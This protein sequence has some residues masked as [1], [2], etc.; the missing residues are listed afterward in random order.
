[1][2]QRTRQCS[3]LMWLKRVRLEPGQCGAFTSIGSLDVS[4]QCPKG[5][6][7]GKSILR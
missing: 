5:L 4:R 2:L 6:A 3:Q 7:V 1:M